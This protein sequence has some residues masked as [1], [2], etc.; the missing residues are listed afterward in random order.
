MPKSGTGSR[1]RRVAKQSVSSDF[2]V[3]VRDFKGGSAIK[4]I[5]DLLSWNPT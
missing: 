5:T 2:R 3:V 1:S 4:E